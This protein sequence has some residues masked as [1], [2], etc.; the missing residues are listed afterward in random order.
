[1][2][3]RRLATLLYVLIVYRLGGKSKSCGDRHPARPVS[4][5]CLL[6]DQS[7]CPEPALS[8]LLLFFS[9]VLCGVRNVPVP[10]PCTT[11]PSVFNFQELNSMRLA[12]WCVVAKP[13]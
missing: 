3:P 11:A 2:E 6:C 7:H 9:A 1:M 13:M 8:L 12:T 4:P 5:V 10:V